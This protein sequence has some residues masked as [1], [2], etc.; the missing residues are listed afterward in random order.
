MPDKKITVLPT[1]LVQK[2]DEHRG[3]LGRGEF[4]DALIQGYLQQDSDAQPGKNSSEKRFVTE[5]SLEEFEQGIKELLR[6][7]LEFLV[8]YGLELGHKRDN[9]GLESL[10]EKLKS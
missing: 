1:E 6:N 8:S 5:E 7:F 2:I 4:L 3:D 9:S 10:S